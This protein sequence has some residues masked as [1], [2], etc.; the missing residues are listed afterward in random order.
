MASLS[1]ALSLSLDPIAVGSQGPQVRPSPALPVPASDMD[2]RSS[3][4]G[5]IDAHAASVQP[6]SRHMDTAS[7]TRALAAQTVLVDIRVAEREALLEAP[8]EGLENLSDAHGIQIVTTPSPIETGTCSA[9]L[10]AWPSEDH[11]H[12]P[13]QVGESIQDYERAT[14]SLDAAWAEGVAPCLDAT[15]AVEVSAAGDP[16]CSAYFRSGTSTLSLTFA[17]GSG[18]VAPSLHII[19]II[20]SLILLAFSITS[21]LKGAIASASYLCGRTYQRTTRHR[22]AAAKLQRAARRR[23]AQQQ[24]P[25]STSQPLL[26]ASVAGT[27]PLKV[28]RRRVPFRLRGAGSDAK[29]V[30]HDPVQPP[31]PPSP[32]PSEMSVVDVVQENTERSMAAAAIHLQSRMRTRQAMSKKEKTLEGMKQER[33]MAAAA[34][35]LQSRMRTRQAMSKKKKTLAALWLQRMV[36]SPQRKGCL[37]QARGRLE[38]ARERLAE[39]RHVVQAA[40]ALL[41]VETSARVAPAWWTES[42]TL[43]EWGE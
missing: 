22:A 11:C 4:G 35:H 40:Q 41:P 1:P 42:R 17:E 23:R 37:E 2:A 15:Q 25:P 3:T 39:V 38:Q 7:E 20:S 30:S 19:L 6:R 21:C 8:I 33:S 31:S 28:P 24:Q 43:G 16:I 14:Q 18:E 32:R 12:L 26:T 34:I 27:P 9:F 29:D 13:E 5:E 36:R 10:S